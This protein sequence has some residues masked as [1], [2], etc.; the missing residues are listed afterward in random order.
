[1]YAFRAFHFGWTEQCLHI[2]YLLVVLHNIVGCISKIIG[3]QLME[4]AIGVDAGRKYK[5]VVTGYVAAS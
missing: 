1:M 2:S 5:M 4:K 3:K